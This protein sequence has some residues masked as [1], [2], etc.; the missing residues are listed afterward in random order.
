MLLL[1]EYL[2]RNTPASGLHAPLDAMLSNGVQ[3]E[4]V[5]GLFLQHTLECEVLREKH[6]FLRHLLALDHEFDKE[7]VF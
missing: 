6:T 7:T 1:H 4:S 3:N 5:F 2:S